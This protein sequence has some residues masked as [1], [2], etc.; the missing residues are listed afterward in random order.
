MPK[1]L[2]KSGRPVPASSEDTTVGVVV[3]PPLA[4]SAVVPHGAEIAGYRVG[5]QLGRGGMGVVYKAH[6][7][8]LDRA[9]ALKVLTPALADNEEFRERFMRESQMAATLHHSNVVTVYDAGEEDGLLYLAMQFVSGTDLRRLLELEGS[10]DPTRTMG[11]L[12]QIGGALDAAHAHDLVHRDVKP[13]NVLVDIDRAYLGDFGLTKRF[14]ATGGLTGVGQIVG[15]VEYLAPEQIEGNGVDGRADQ[16]ALACVAY[17]CLSGRPPHSKD[18][19]IAILFAHVREDPTPLTGLLDDIPSGVD[20]VMRKALAKDPRDR[21]SSGREF[22]YDLASEL[23]VDSAGLASQEPS[24]HVVVASD[25]PTTR[26]IVR[27]SLANMGVSVSEVAGDALP[28]WLGERRFDALIA[29]ASLAPET[30]TTLRT[31]M[32]AG[33]A[34]SAPKLLVLVPRDERGASNSGLADADDELGQPFSGMQLALK[35]RRLLGPQAVK[36]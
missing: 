16:Y 17:E 34:G 19:D 27:G 24:S 2:R 32:Q 31:A 18:S 20:D 13:A 28:S 9:A 21:Y 8:R 3:R 35:L 7:I 36:A 12:A 6:H 33:A 30:L 26:A 29:D 15:T 11:I 14:D 10:L 23:G 25:D 1:F 4:E 5:P 22:V